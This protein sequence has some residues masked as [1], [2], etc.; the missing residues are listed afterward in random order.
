MIERIAA[1]PIAFFDV[2]PL[3]RVINRF[4]NDMSKVD[5]LLTMLVMFTVQLA[6]I[7]I[8]ASLAVVVITKGAMLIVLIPLVII[9]MNIL[10]FIQT[11]QIQIQR[12]EATF[13]SPIYANFSE[14]LTGLPV[15]R[16]VLIPFP[17]TLYS[18]FSMVFFALSID[19]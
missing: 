19:V 11:S 4:S 16:W 10:R 7:A 5:F 15:I 8:A 12:I 13:R 9:Y 14:I 3:G 17:L 2:T 6:I 1:A 18:V